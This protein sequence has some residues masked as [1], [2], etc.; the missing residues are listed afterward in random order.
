MI[1]GSPFFDLQFGAE[2]AVAFL[3]RCAA[4]LR[5]GGFIFLKENVCPKGFIVDSEDASV[6]RSHAY[7]TELTTKMAGLSLVS[8]ARQ[9]NFP[10]PLFPV[11]MY[12][13][14]RKA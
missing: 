8:T 9:Q 4:A 7:L 13:L 6:T 14:A 1:D 3:Q 12:A 10:K 2:D 11:R 5:P